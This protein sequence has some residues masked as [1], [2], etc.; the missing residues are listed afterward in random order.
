MPRTLS[1]V[2]VLLAG[3]AGLA[4]LGRVHAQASALGTTPLVWEQLEVREGALHYALALPKDLDPARPTPV[5]VGFP[6]GVQDRAMAEWAYGAIWAPLVAEGWIVACPVAKEGEVLFRGHDARLRMLLH[7]LAVRFTPEGGRV[8]AAG[9]SNGGRAAIALAAHN[10][11]FVSDVLAFPGQAP[12]PLHPELK[13]ARWTTF[14]L[15]AG[16]KDARW[17]ASGRATVEA[18]TAAGIAASFEVL[19]GA[20]HVPHELFG[21]RFVAMCRETRAR[22]DEPDP[23]R[24][25]VRD[26]LGDFH[27]AATKADAERYFGRFTADGVFLGSD[28]DE[29]WDVPAFRAWAQPYFARESAWSF[30]PLVQHVTVDAGGEVAWFDEVVGSD[31][32]GACRGS[33]VLRLVDGSWKVALYDLTVPVPNDLLDAVTAAIDRRGSAPLEPVTVLLVRHAEKAEVGDDPE[34]SP[35]GRARAEA[36]AALLARTPIDAAY[37][38]P[39]QRTVQTLAPLASAKGLTVQTMDA[40]DVGALRRH[41]VAEHAGQTVVIAGHSNTVQ[42]IARAFGVHDAPALTEADYGDLFVIRCGVFGSAM[43]R[44]SFG[45]R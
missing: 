18:L 1:I 33:G 26:A 3:L 44:L 16:E 24:R 45:G 19:P 36:L 7:R 38:S 30:A 20:E 4:G 31:Y 5:L 12:L 9:T 27:D 41:V 6:P 15:L 29:R 37:S 40:A 23:V 35:A 14:R 32:M 8:V 21:E 43:L 10:P 34:L 2:T 42:Q 25:A 13:R 28:P 11:Y 17:V 22:R 39:Y